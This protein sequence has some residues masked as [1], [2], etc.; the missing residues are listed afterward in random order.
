MRRRTRIG[1]EALAPEDPSA[2]VTWDAQW[3]M[4]PVFDGVPYRDFVHPNRAPENNGEIQNVHTLFRREFN[5]PDAAIRRARL[6]V[7]ADDCYTL[8]LNGDFVGFGPAPA[9]PFAYHTW[10][11]TAIYTPW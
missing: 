8:Y 3:L 11:T 6:Y 10:V 9:Y 4:D 5:V 1:A 7:T 2:S